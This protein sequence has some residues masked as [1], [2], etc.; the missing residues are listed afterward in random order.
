MVVKM[1][2][3]EN[4][5]GFWDLEALNGFALTKEEKEEVEYSSI[6]AWL[7]LNSASLLRITICAQHCL[8]ISTF[9][10]LEFVSLCYIVYF[11]AVYKRL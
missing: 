7:V 2:Q 11:S 8:H 6:P 10:W 3:S 4:Y 1:P 9:K 5:I